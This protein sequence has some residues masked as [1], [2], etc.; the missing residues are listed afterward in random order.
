MSEDLKL[1]LG[2]NKNGKG[3]G[4]SLLILLVALAVVL[5]VLN[6]V[7][8]LRG[9]G[10]REA[11]SLRGDEM[12]SL[13]LKLEKQG[14]GLAAAEVWIDYL[15][16][17]SPGKDETARIW[18][19]IGRARQESGEFEGALV[20]FYTSEGISAVP[21]LEQEISIRIEQC[22]ERLGRFAAM[23]SE[24]ERRTSLDDE[25]GGD[26][27]IAEIETWKLTRS[28]LTGM[29]EDEID[30]Q[31]YQVAG[32][33][34]PEQVRARKEQLLDEVMKGGKL[35]EWLETIIAEELLYRYA[36]EEKIH[37]DTRVRGLVGKMERSIIIQKA[38][39]REYGE[40]ISINEGE[41]EA[42]YRDHAA[43]LAQG[44]EIQ[45][46]EEVKQQVYAAVRME[47][48]REVHMR[49][50]GELHTRY[51]VVIHRSKLAG[52]TEPEE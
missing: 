32:S 25:A 4:G 15:Q 42:W 21:E 18:Y 16:V 7:L 29:I 8:L 44:G 37:E 28:M 48:E 41:L 46:Y 38:L 24:L 52:D 5:G 2:R 27:V 33:M 13:A 23:R 20:A 17:A 3:R 36:I 40:S 6:L 1:S 11:G 31:L 14:F 10:S 45:P 47:K 49:L 43:D 34:Q 35:A 39:E 26:E 9:V 50:L 19:R 22:L 30:S 12:E 51:D